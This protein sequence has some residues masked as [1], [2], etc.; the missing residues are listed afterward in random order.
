MIDKTIV[1]LDFQTR[2]EVESF[3]DKATEAQFVKVG[4]ELFYSE[5]P[6]IVQALKDRGL[7]VFVDLKV[8]DIPNTAYGAIRSLARLG[9]DI[10]NVHASGGIEMMRKAKEAL[11]EHG[12]ADTK[13]IGV[14][15]LTSMD[16]A[17]LQSELQINLS[18]HDAVANLAKNAHTAGLDGIVCSPLEAAQ[19]KAATSK[20]FV[21]VCPGVRFAEAGGFAKQGDQKR[22]MTPEDAF[23]NGADY[24]VMGRAITQAED[25]N[26]A[27]DLLANAQ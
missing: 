23:S 9:V 18:I 20:D 8:H 2:S 17:T 1:A 26:E 15:Y 12:G 19:V 16:E 7:K 10:L 24:I 3:L 14:T 4:M 21:T 25:P 5:G 6:A 27:L 22:V 13:L 11:V